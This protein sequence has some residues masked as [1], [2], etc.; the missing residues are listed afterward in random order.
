MPPLQRIFGRPFVGQQVKL[1][2][3]GNTPLNS[4][5]FTVIST[6]EFSRAPIAALES[7]ASV[8]EHDG[9]DGSNAANGTK[10]RVLFRKEQ[11]ELLERTYLG[12]QTQISYLF[13][14]CRQRVHQ[15]KGAT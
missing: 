1:F 5:C 6:A 8:D 11:V 12:G 13:G 2:F 15:R 7:V 9:V 10:R 14:H 4:P 3:E